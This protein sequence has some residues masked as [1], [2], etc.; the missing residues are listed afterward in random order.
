MNEHIH[1]LFH[2]IYGR[3]NNTM[4]QVLEFKQDYLNG[5]FDDVLSA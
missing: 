5:K 3:V 4:E 2:S 1:K